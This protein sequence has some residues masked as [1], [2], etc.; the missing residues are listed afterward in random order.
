[1]SR[2]CSTCETVS[3]LPYVKS[4]LS[5][6]DTLSLTLNPTQYQCFQ[7]KKIFTEEEYKG[8]GEGGF[9]PVFQMFYVEGDIKR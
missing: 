5:P 9:I 4:M 3:I 6:L 8:L 7:C 1:M 2:Q